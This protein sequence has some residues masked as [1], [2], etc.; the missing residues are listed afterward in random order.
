MVMIEGKRSK[1]EIHKGKQKVD[2]RKYKL[3]ITINA[4]CLKSL[5]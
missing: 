4:N 5:V 2:K 1:N 3:T